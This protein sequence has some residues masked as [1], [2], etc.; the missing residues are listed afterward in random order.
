[1]RKRGYESEEWERMRGVER[2]WKKERKK[3]EGLH[4]ECVRMK[5]RTNR[6]EGDK[7]MN[8]KEVEWRVEQREMKENE[9]W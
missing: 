6:R 5:Q 3:K 2:T 9:R 4:K 1:M 7:M 8:E